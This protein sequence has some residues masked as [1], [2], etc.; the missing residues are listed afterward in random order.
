MASVNEEGKLVIGV[1]DGQPPVILECSRIAGLRMIA[2]IASA[3]A[4]TRQ[5]LFS[6]IDPGEAEEDFEGE[7]SSE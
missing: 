2:A 7:D 5:E 1:I 3:L 6:T 4:A